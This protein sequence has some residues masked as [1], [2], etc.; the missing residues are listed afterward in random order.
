M[1]TYLEKKK[2]QTR[3]FK[4]H[5]DGVEIASFH[6]EVKGR[7]RKAGSVES[8][9]YAENDGVIYRHTFTAWG[10]SNSGHGRV[11]DI[12]DRDDIEKTRARLKNYEREV[13]A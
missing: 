11:V 8:I 5:L 2:E 1:T 12:V 7:G 3:L 9:S 13:R 6:K 10:G 4:L